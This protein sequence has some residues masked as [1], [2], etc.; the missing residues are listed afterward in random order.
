[1][2]ALGNE[3]KHR[4]GKIHGTI[5]IMQTVDLVSLALDYYPR[6][7]ISVEQTQPALAMPPWHKV[8]NNPVQS[9]RNYYRDGKIVS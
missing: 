7:L 1:M 9:Y 6:D 2:I 5:L 3:Y 8:K 4:R